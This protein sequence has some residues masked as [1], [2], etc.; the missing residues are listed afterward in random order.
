MPKKSKKT[1]AIEKAAEK[2]AKR[3]GKDR[4]SLMPET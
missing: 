4:K 3:A 1:I 2:E